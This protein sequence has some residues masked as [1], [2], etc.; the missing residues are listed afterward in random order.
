[1]VRP[2]PFLFSLGIS[3]PI[4]FAVVQVPLQVWCQKNVSASAFF[5]Y[6]NIV[7]QDRVKV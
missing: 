1:M 6:I 4:P 3:P 5:K 2:N 7:S